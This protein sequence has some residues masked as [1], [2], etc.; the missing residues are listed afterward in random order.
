MVWLRVRECKARH[1]K[2]WCGDQLAGWL[3]G[4]LS[5]P[6]RN[7]RLP[8]VSIREAL[9]NPLKCNGFT[10][11]RNDSSVQ[12]DEFTLQFFGVVAGRN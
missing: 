12:F 7:D 5:F 11:I 3:A 9:S 6:A 4:W 2:F 1:R 8:A 10:A